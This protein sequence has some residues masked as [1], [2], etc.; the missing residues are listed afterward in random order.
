MVGQNEVQTCQGGERNRARILPGYRLAAM[1]ERQPLIPAK[2][3]AKPG[4]RAVQPQ[5]FEVHFSAERANPA[6]VASSRH[7]SPVTMTTGVD[8]WSPATAGDT[9]NLYVDEWHPRSSTM[10][11][12]C[13]ESFS[14]RPD[15]ASRAVR[16][17][18]PRASGLRERIVV[19][20]SSSTMSTRYQPCIGLSINY[21]KLDAC[22][23]STRLHV[24]TRGCVNFTHPGH[25]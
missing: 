19:A 1:P 21:R 4:S 12:G 13:Y 23:G 10:A 17:R 16:P 20:P 6:I 2:E 11:S 7:W 22:A 5:R 3:L 9:G 25:S 15:S 8:E 24:A 14:R 18:S